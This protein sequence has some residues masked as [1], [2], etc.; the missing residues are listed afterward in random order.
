MALTPGTKKDQQPSP[1]TAMRM[2]RE[3]DEQASTA[4]SA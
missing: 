1:A 3:H 4:A 2:L